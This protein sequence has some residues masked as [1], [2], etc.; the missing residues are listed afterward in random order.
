MF[1]FP[2]LSPSLPPSPG[3][4]VRHQRQ[5]RRLAAVRESRLFTSARRLEA[6]KIPSVIRSGGDPRRGLGRGCV[7]VQV[8]PADGGGDGGKEGA[9]EGEGGLGGIVSL[10][11]LRKITEERI[12]CMEDKKQRKGLLV[13]LENIVC[14]RCDLNIQNSTALVAQ[15][16]LLHLLKAKHASPPSTNSRRVPLPLLFFFCFRVIILISLPILHTHTTL[17]PSTCTHSHTE[18]P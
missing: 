15:R 16:H 11:Y 17:S 1:S 5:H 13:C 2:S 4:P 6:K 9:K 3:L 18:K 12:K 8:H 14:C 10:R 7:Y